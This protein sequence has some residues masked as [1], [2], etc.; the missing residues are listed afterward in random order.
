MVYNRL[1]NIFVYFWL[2]NILKK[3]EDTFT[4][5]T[6]SCGDCISTVNDI[7]TS[8]CIISGFFFLP[9]HGKDCTK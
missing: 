6:D 2:K 9:F 7:D 5:C 8:A 4:L 3:C 1:I